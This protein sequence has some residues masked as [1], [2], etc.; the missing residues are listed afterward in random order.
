MILSPEDV[1]LL[2]DRVVQVKDIETIDVEK[3]ILTVNWRGNAST[4]LV[5]ES[6]LQC[7]QKLPHTFFRAT[8]DCLINMTHVAKVDSLYRN[9][10]ITMKTGRKLTLSRTRTREFRK[11]FSL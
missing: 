9:L 11:R 8:R 2:K 1:V 10:V 7:A 4:G 5:Q 6:L 3:N